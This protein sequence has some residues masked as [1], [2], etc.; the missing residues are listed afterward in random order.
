[1]SEQ[2]ARFESVRIPDVITSNPIPPPI[3][4]SLPIMARP[5]R[6]L[7]FLFGSLALLNGLVMAPMGAACLL[8]LPH[9]EPALD[10]RTLLADCAVVAAV[11]LCLPYGVMMLGVAVTCFKDGLQRRKV[12]LE[13]AADGLRDHRSGIDIPWSAIRSADISGRTNGVDLRLREEKA[14]WQNPFRI[15]VVLQR[16]RPKPEH[17]IVSVGSLDVSA[18]V[19]AYSI[20]TQ[21]HWHGGETV[22]VPTYHYSRLIARPN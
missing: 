19:L 20:L 1:M 5:R 2:E 3:A 17:V 18:H 4:I 11:A 6:W 10:F 14:I 9:L 22:G 12:A 15:G 8:L 16:W 7:N 21:V 13:I